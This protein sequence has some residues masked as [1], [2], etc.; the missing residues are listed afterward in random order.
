MVESGFESSKR[1]RPL[2][3]ESDQKQKVDS[4][5]EFG[6]EDVKDKVANTSDDNLEEEKIGKQVLFPKTLPL[7]ESVSFDDQIIVVKILFLLKILSFLWFPY[8]ENLCVPLLLFNFSFPMF[9]GVFAY[10]LKHLTTLSFAS[11]SLG[12]S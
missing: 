7:V 4:N 9:L 8:Y 3:S 6:E 2:D 11:R 10:C 12:K 5:K 1:V